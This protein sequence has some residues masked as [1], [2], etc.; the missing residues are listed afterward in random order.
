[1]KKNLFIWQVVGL[2]FTAVLGT[3]LHFLYEWTGLTLIAPFS[4]VNESTWEH[5]KLVFIPS[6]IFATAQSFF[7]SEFKSF[8]L[9]KLI[10]ILLGTLLIAVLFY[11]LTGVFG[12]LTPAT[13]VAIFF[14]SVTIQYFVELILFSNLN[15][16]KNLN[17]IC[18]AVLLIVLVLFIVYTFF[19]P[20]IPLFIPKKM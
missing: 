14:A 11:T 16:N 4:A 3:V 9:V 17:L 7:A 1:M 10:G 8:W 20:K 6:L 15:C 19:P 5:M 2:T 13:N 12:T 18:V